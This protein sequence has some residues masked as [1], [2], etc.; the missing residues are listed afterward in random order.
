MRYNSNTGDIFFLMKGFNN[1]KIFSGFYQS[2]AFRV[3]NFQQINPIKLNLH[4]RIFCQRGWGLFFIKSLT[5]INI[6][7]VQVLTLSDM[8]RLNNLKKAIR[9]FNRIKLKKI[10]KYFALTSCVIINNNFMFL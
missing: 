1:K 4:V 7:Y 3:L 5:E 8:T 6:Q 2:S 9:D 10:S